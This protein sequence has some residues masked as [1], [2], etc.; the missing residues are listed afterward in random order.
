ME[1]AFT[2]RRRA[3]EFVKQGSYAEAADAYRREAA[4]RR[5]DGDVNAARVEEMKA[6]RWSSEIRP[7]IHLPGKATHGDPLA[8]WEPPYGCYIGAFLD[9]DERLG[10]PFRDENW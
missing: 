5:R 2:W 9:R 10:R 6:D 3:E 1:S 8:R 4:I 7:F